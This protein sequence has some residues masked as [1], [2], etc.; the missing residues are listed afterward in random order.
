MSLGRKQDGHILEV[1]PR[2]SRSLTLHSVMGGGASAR[3]T[4][5]FVVTAVVDKFQIDVVVLGLS[6]DAEA[7][8]L[9]AGEDDANELSKRGRVEGNNTIG[10]AAFCV[11][12]IHAVARDGC[13]CNAAHGL[14]PANG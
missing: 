8:G 10:A 13:L 2:G 12:G 7:S 11:L 9:D 4:R 3:S 14:Q 6:A 5:F 1:E